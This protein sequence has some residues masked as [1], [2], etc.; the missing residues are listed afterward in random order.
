MTTEYI[1]TN[2]EMKPL[3]NN[4]HSTK[5][6]ECRGV[7]KALIYNKEKEEIVRKITFMPGCSLGVPQGTTTPSS[8]VQAFEKSGAVAPT[9]LVLEMLNLK[10]SKQNHSS[11]KFHQKFNFTHLVGKRKCIWELGYC[12]FQLSTVTIHILSVINQLNQ[13][14]LLQHNLKKNK[15][16]INHHCQTSNQKNIIGINCLIIYGVVLLRRNKKMVGNFGGC[17]NQ[18]QVLAEDEKNETLASPLV[19][20][21]HYSLL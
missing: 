6:V 2:D 21:Q 13:T 9:P 10:E 12:I 14:R 11:Y 7:Y 17:L 3:A 15:G 20:C 18:T 4:G 5:G 19:I 8:S 16:N 1:L